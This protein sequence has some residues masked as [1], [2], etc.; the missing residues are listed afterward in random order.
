MLKSGLS[1]LYKMLGAA[2]TAQFTL[3]PQGMPFRVSAPPEDPR[4]WHD[5]RDPK[6][7]D[8]MQVAKD[9]R[10]R[11]A[12]KNHVCHKVAWKNNRAI[13]GAFCKWDDLILLSHVEPLNLNPF[14]VAK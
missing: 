11:R 4:Y 13:H 8:R 6:H 3:R 2:L 10:E 9:R 5:P 7:L 1:A 12:E 14:Y